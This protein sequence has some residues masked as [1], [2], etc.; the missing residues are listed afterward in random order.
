MS[1][2]IIP[3]FGEFQ[4]VYGI[5][6]P[7][8]VYTRL[9]NDMDTPVSAYLKIAKGKPYAFLFE[10]VQGGEQRGRYSFMGFS[11]DL[12]WRSFDD[13]SECA[14]GDDSFKP[15]TGNPLDSLRTIQTES[16]FDLP[17][18]IP[19]MASGLFGYLGYDMIR[20]VEKLPNINSDPIGT[21]D[22]IMTRPTIVA[23]FDQIAQE[24]TITTTVYP[25]NLSAQSAYDAALKRLE[26]VVHDMSLPVQGS[27]NRTDNYQDKI[28]PKI[29]TSA[30]NF[31][32]RV[33]KAKAYIEAGDIFQVV[34]GQRLEADMPA[35]NFSLYRALRR[36]N[37]SPFLYFLE[38]DDHAIVGSS[39]EILVRLRDDVV[40]IRPIAG[41]R[42]RG[43]TA[44]EDL[45][46]E[47]SLLADPK[48]RAEHL[49]LL[50]LG[51][52]DVGRVAKAGTVKVTEEFIIE[53]YS[54]VMHIVSNVEGEI[55]D[56]YDA[57]SALFAGFPA[58]TVSGAP[59]VRAM[60][61]ID[62]LEDEK[63]GIYG[64]A[65]GYI[66]CQGDMDTAIALRTGIVKDGKLHVRAGAGIVADSTPQY[67]YDECRY[68]AAALFRAAEASVLF[69]GN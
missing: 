32:Q 42:P 1:S 38:F 4:S 29:I 13:V 27:S 66:S 28:S 63:R 14:R 25:N 22:A 48:E 36:L 2:D 67:E 15:L 20:Q 41:T 69:E 49:M 9:I 16:A 55:R 60:E 47:K 7:Q 37:P 12:I 65:V 44:A 21:P 39:P 58:G 54:H 26:A 30:E 64:G 17:E 5:G 35:S 19:P 24:I 40:T 34:I 53:R 8:L 31:H 62:E 61:I 46:N 11:P 43:K 59:K 6:R 45:E 3:S 50:D 56:D 10:S 68:K 23:I 52:N 18:G 57:L 33:D 51:R